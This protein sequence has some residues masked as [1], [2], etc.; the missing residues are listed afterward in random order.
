MSRRIALLVALAVPALA[1]AQESVYKKAVKSTVWVVQ[2]LDGNKIRMGSGAL[3]DAQ[4]RLILTNHHVVADKKDVTV[5]FPVIDKGNV[6]QDRAAYNDR[7]KNGLGIAGKVLFTEPSK[8]LA[9]IQLASV[10]PGIQPIRLAKES[11]GPAIMCIR[12][13]APASALAC[14]TTPAAT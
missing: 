5:M 9:I 1:P 13:A 2:P 8:D 6:L 7:L 12:S 14:S 10:P 4:K 3:I 11:P